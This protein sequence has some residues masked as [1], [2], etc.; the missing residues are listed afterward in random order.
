MSQVNVG[1]LQAGLNAIA[2][3]AWVGGVGLVQSI[4]FEEGSRPG[5]PWN[6]ILAVTHNYSDA[7]VS[8]N[9]FTVIYNFGFFTPLPTY[10]SKLI[11]G[12][13]IWVDAILIGKDKETSFFIAEV[14][15][16]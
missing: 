4:T 3:R 9:K 13:K 5:M 12:E 1:P 7:L 15:C 8:R 10:W 6:A 16:N 11:V 14:R 2:R